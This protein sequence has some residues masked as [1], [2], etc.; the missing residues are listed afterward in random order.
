MRWMGRSLMGLFLLALTL[1]LLAMAAGS[2]RSTL[3]DRWARQARIRPAE[4]RVFAVSVVLAEPG[5]VVP[6]IESFGEIRSRR[7]LDLRAP[8]AGTIQHREDPLA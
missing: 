7:S 3:Q 4:E 1:G 5:Q 6:V 2:L 8:A